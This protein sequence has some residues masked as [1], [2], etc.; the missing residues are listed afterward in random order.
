MVRQAVYHSYDNSWANTIPGIKLITAPRDI[1]GLCCC[2]CFC[3]RGVVDYGA[4]QGRPHGPDFRWTSRSISHLIFQFSVDPGDAE[5]EKGTGLLVLAKFAE[6]LPT[7]VS[8]RYTNADGQVNHVEMRKSLDDP[9]FGARI[10]NITAATKYQVEFQ[11]TKSDE[12]EVSVFE[13]PELIRS[14]AEIDFPEYTNLENKIAQDIRRVTAVEGSTAQLDFH[15][16]K[17]VK[18]AT[19]VSDS[20]EVIQLDQSSLPNT[21]KTEIDFNEIGKQTY[22]LKLTDSEN[23]ANKSPPRIVFNTLENKIPEL[24]ISG[25]SPD[26]QISA[27]EEILL[28]AKSFDDFGISRI[29][30][31][32]SIGDKDDAQIVLTGGNGEKKQEA[33]H[34]LAMEELEAEA[35]QFLTYHVWAEDFGPDGNVRRVA[36]DIFFAEVRP[37]DEI[38]RQGEAPPGGA[39]Q[40]QQQQQQGQNA[41]NAEQA[42]QLAE[43]QKQIITATWNLIR[44]ETGEEPT[45]EF[46]TDM[47]VMIESQQSALAQVE[48]L[49]G[50]VD[51]ENSKNFLDE[52][53]SF[54]NSAINDF[55]T[56]RDES[57]TSNLD[58]AVKNAKGAYQALLKL[59][60]RE[61]EVVRQQQ[62]Q[63]QQQQQSQAQNQRQQQMNQLD[64]EQDQNQYEQQQQ[65]QLQDEQETE[66][67]ENRQIL[68]RLRELAQRQNDLNKRVKEL[69]S[70]LLES[71]T[72]EEQEEN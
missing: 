26:M 58:S 52:S 55:R 46:A 25:P 30:L 13:F 44:R 72:E 16:N 33:E 14:D 40:Q 43:L 67:Q 8:I 18:S 47:D 56:G 34:L 21:F 11:E 36:S 45:E 64:M 69:Q 65:A 39:Q 1:T 15:L 53:R 68:S 4:T 70:A 60:S 59:R 27:L 10:P 20:G 29:G 63:Q 61:H 9:V 32:Y 17:S 38:Y 37:F 12:F 24:K 54:M 31:T 23:R 66:Q 41:Q 48:E 57:N 35:D 22:R 42:Q 28:K 51:D 5:V 62:Q 19:L 6:S 2:V 71:E 49:A 50:A 3:N 7:E